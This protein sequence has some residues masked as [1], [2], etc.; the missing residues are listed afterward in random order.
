M[1]GS[2]YFEQGAKAYDIIDGDI[3]GNVQITSNVDT[4]YAGIYKVVY[5]VTNSSG[6]EVFTEREVRVIAP[7]IVVL[8]RVSHKLSGKGKEKE[9]ITHKG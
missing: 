2:P 8:P 1:G 7:K 5:S 3:S 6:M 4:N 9:T